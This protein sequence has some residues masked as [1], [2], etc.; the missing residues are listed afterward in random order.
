MNKSDV[1]VIGLG[2]M[3]SNLA[4]NLASRGYHV[5]VFNRHP[6]RVR[7]FL[8]KLEKEFGAGSPKATPGGR[9][10]Y[11][12]LKEN[13][14]TAFSFDQLMEQ[15]AEPRRILLMVKAGEAVDE[16]L[17]RL[18]PRLAAGDVVMDGGNSFY[19]DTERR[20]RSFRGTGIRFIGCGISGGADGALHG[21]SIMAGG[22]EEGWPAVRQMLTDAAAVSPSDGRPCCLWMGKGG[23]GHFVKMVHN[24]IEYAE[25]EAIAE[26]FDLMK[27]GL[28]IGYWQMSEIFNRW[29]QSDDGGYLLEITTRILQKKTDHLHLLDMIL[30]VAR[31]KGTGR[32][33][34]AAA[35]NYDIDV[36]LLSAAVMQRSASTRKELRTT[37]AESYRIDDLHPL[38]NDCAAPQQHEGQAAPPFP[39]PD[40]ESIRKAFR[41]CKMLIF[42]QGFSLLHAASRQEG[43]GLSLED[44]AAVWRAGCILRSPLLERLKGAFLYD[45]QCPSLLLSGVYRNELPACVDALK[46]VVAFA[47][48]RHLPCPVLS[49]ALQYFLTMATA[50][51]PLYLTQAQRDYFGAHQIERTDRP[52]G[53]MFHLEWEEIAL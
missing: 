47:N 9:Y 29:E 5:S 31:Q 23:A 30:D 48:S 2:V 21:P 16:M 44:A 17:A 49:T 11:D 32:W 7:D 33:C 20:C 39:V 25:M 35:M 26:I 6:E 42:S 45:P 51:L 37:L 46:S 41:M 24:G 4:I 18:R 3:G 10:D 14:T 12:K 19:E 15:L 52:R 34:I 8:G 1:A 50:R 28:D 27:R 13:L 36:S 22:D 43:Y 53:E 38:C 40:Q